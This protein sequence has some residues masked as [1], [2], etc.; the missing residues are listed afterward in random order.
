MVNNKKPTPF[1]KSKTCVQRNHCIMNGTLQ[2]V[3]HLNPSV[4][5]SDKQCHTHVNNCQHA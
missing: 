3:I 2:D 1:S 5:C 4:I